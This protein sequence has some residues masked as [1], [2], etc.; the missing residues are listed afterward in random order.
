MVDGLSE[1]IFRL[2]GLAHAVLDLGD[3]AIR[4]ARFEADGWIVAALFGEV[5]VKREGFFQELA[6]NRFHLRLVGEPLLGD[7]RVHVVDGLARLV[8]ICL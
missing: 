6:L 3:S 1:S 2:R 5:S 8:G 7:L 4:A